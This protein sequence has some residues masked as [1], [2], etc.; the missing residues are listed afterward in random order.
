MT[1]DAKCSS[2]ATAGGARRDRRLDART[3]MA[4]IKNIARRAGMNLEAQPIWTPGWRT[5]H[6]SRDVPAVRGEG[7]RSRS[8][9]FSEAKIGGLS[10]NGTSGRVAAISTPPGTRQKLR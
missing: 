2:S 10:R 8:G 9:V 5:G 7:P 6:A 3:L 1:G 4:A